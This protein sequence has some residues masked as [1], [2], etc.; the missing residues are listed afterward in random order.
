MTSAAEYA[1]F[2]TSS[3]SPPAKS[4][5]GP[6]SPRKNH[7]KHLE[8]DPFMTLPLDKITIPQLSAPSSNA[9]DAEGE[10]QDGPE[11]SEDM[12]STITRVVMTPLLFTSFLISLLFVDHKHRA[13]R[14]SEHP[15]YPSEESS[16]WARLSPFSW[17]DP[18]PYQEPSDTSWQTDDSAGSTRPVESGRRGSLGRKWFHRKK[19]RGVAKMEIAEAFEVRERVMVML[20]A[21]VLMC[22]GAVGYGVRWL[23]E[24]G[25]FW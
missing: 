17:L 25:R 12:Y 5:N 19:H 15:S 20:I 21:G 11:Q 16:F 13:Y 18:E 7:R 10:Q 24:R 22:A 6:S 4:S 8:K 1:S 9:G 23:V 2:Q 14:A 3:P